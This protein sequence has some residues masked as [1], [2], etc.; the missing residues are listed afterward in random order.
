ME[1]FTSTQ[2][3]VP[4][5]Q[6]VLLLGLTTVSLLI[7]RLKL[8]LLINYCFTLYW[9]YIANIDLFSFSTAGRMV[10]NKYTFFYFG[11]GLVVLFLATVGLMT[12]RD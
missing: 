8:A 12:Q 7:G 6:V 9:G 10:L 5:M 3:T 4:I 1:P 2:L 11:F